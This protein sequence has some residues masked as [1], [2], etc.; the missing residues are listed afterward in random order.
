MNKAKRRVLI[1]IV[2]Y[3]AEKTL[4]EVLN[5]IPPAVLDYDYR[6]LIIDDSSSDQT[7]ARGIDYQRSHPDL[8]LEILCNPIN[9]GYGGNQKLGYQYAMQI[10]G[11]N[12]LSWPRRVYL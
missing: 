11:I 6:I 8:N 5:R 1:F 9:Q 4:A 12:A 10:A 2:A 7:F 3:N